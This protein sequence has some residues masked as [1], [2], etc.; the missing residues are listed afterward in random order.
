[1]LA[2]DKVRL[3]CCLCAMAAIIAY[4][5]LR[6][7]SVSYK[8][9]RRLS[10]P[11]D[12]A[13]TDVRWTRPEAQSTEANAVQSHYYTLKDSGGMIAVLRGRSP[14]PFMNVSIDPRTLPQHDL[15]Q[16]K[17]GIR[18]DSYEA[19]LRILEDFGS[20][21]PSFSE[22]NRLPTFLLSPAPPPQFRRVAF[23]AP[24]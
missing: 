4:F 24:V 6:A 13:A 3:A 11:A 9:P 19:L 15:E 22:E 21:F 5:K 17:T 10:S 7:S 8:R 16:L 2:K 23:D 18:V 14:Q 12:A 1:M 20:Y